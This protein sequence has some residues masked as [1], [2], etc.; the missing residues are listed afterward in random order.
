MPDLTGVCASGAG[1]ATSW[2]TASRIQASERGADG[3]RLYRTLGWALAGVI[4]EF[5]ASPEGGLRS[6]SFYYRL[7]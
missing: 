1:A 4:P 5:A 3:E 7:I 2:R 6:S